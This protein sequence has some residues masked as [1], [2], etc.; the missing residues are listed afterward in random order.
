MVAAR[1]DPT[2]P[3]TTDESLAT[4]DATALIG[5]LASRRMPARLG[6]PLAATMR[7]DVQ[8]ARARAHAGRSTRTHRRPEGPVETGRQP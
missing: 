2:R 8:L 5:K 6:F 7:R 1:L 3:C 4:Q